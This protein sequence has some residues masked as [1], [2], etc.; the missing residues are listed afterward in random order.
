MQAQT[1]QTRADGLPCY[2]TLATSS[3]PLQQS[4][5]F[6]ILTIAHALQHCDKPTQFAKF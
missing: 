6:P 4:K 5:Q 3:T 1:I 2:F